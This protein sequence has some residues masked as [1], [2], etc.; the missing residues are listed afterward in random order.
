M[1][2]TVESDGL[3]GVFVNIALVEASG[4]ACVD[5]YFTVFSGSRM[6]SS[7][8]RFGPFPM[9]LCSM[10]VVNGVTVGTS[11]N[12]VDGPTTVASAFTANTN[13]KFIVELVIR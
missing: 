5:Q 8:T 10:P 4:S 7:A 3:S 6:N 2:G 13:G 1:T 11:K 12:G 9:D